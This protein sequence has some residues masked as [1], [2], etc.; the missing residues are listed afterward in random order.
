M[1]DRGL[2]KSEHYRGYARRR[3]GKRTSKAAQC[4]LRFMYRRQNMGALQ[5]GELHECGSAPSTL[6]RAHRVRRGTHDCRPRV[7]D[8][9]WQTARANQLA[10]RGRRW[11]NCAIAPRGACNCCFIF[12]VVIS[13]DLDALAAGA[14][15]KRTRRA[16]QHRA[17]PGEAC[18]LPYPGRTT[19]TK[20]TAV[21]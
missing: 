16:W 8:D 4:H 11:K 9:G 5:G 17:R 14:R 6:L 12:D 15:T 2:V 3:P 19:N 7:C 21:R 20:R 1:H 13:R 18:G 10:K